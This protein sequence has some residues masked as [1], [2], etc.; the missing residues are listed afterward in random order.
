MNTVRVNAS[1]SYD[2]LIGSGLL[3]TLGSH[4]AAMKKARKVCIVSEANVWPLY[5]E[6]AKSSL[7]RAGLEVAEFIFPAGEQF[8]NAAVYLNLLYYLADQQLTRTDL[9][10]AL[11]GGVVG[12][13][14]GFAAATYMRGIPFIQIPTTLLAAVDS[15]VGGKTAI[16]LPVGKNLVGAFYQPALVLC[17]TDCLNTLPEDIFRDG[18]AEVIK[19]GIL[20]DPALFAH[21]AEKGL[22]FDREMVITRCVELKRDVVAEDEF[23]TGARMKLNL[24]H[25]IGH[26]AEAQ[27]H[28]EISHG[29]GVAIGM[30]IVS[31][32][33]AAR[34]ICDNGTKDAILS[35]LDKFRLPV[36]CD[37]S[38]E[39]LYRA[40]L[41]DKKRSGGTVNLIIPERIGFCRIEPTPVENIQSF[42]E[43][44]L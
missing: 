11:G 6:R 12:D 19:Y 21:L 20:Y 29:K 8:K 31:R 43:A 22:D 42:I 27:S 13:L 4:A 30:A 17:D 10:V 28:F 24:G 15:S 40:A 25:T 34:G 7:L 33:G 1:R 3:D 44:G 38:A 35:I 5:G 14:A 16:D 37:Y 36:S 39:S 26:G 18:C 23:D 9:I 2:V 41:S 32:A